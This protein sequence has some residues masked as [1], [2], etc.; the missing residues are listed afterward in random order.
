MAR[1]FASPM[2]S[3][4]AAQK[5]AEH[6]SQAALESV[7]RLKK[8]SW[9][10]GL[11]PAPKAAGAGN[12]DL[13]RNTPP[14]GVLRTAQTASSFAHAEEETEVIPFG[15]YSARSRVNRNLP[16]HQVGPWTVME[17]GGNDKGEGFRV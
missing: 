1:R 16:Q 7:A 4:I 6:A 15:E 5:D 10:A 14:G 17:V 9:A 3:M 11:E 8:T 2:L 13:S 12:S